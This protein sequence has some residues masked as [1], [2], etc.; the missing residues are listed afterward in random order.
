MN[1]YSLYLTTLIL[2][3]C[4]KDQR[5]QAYLEKEDN[6]A[7]FLGGHLNINHDTKTVEFTHPVLIDR[8]I[9]AMDVDESTPVKTPAEYSSLPKDENSF[10]CNSTFEYVSIVGMLLYLQNN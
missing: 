2:I 6:V 5:C 1:V 10:T 7:G 8:I 4:Y 3:P 9:H